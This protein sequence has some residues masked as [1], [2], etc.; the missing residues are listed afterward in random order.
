MKGISRKALRELRARVRELAPNLSADRE[1]EI[2]ERSAQTQLEACEKEHKE[3]VREIKEGVERD[4]YK[5]Y[6]QGTE[7]DELWQAFWQKY[8]GDKE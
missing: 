2:S 1:G 8:L 5:P 6:P 4:W 7:A 3:R